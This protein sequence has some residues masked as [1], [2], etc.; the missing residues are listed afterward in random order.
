MMAIKRN[1]SW[2][3]PLLENDIRSHYY[4]LHLLLGQLCLPLVKQR[5]G[6]VSGRFAFVSPS[7]PTATCARPKWKAIQLNRSN[8]ENKGHVLQSRLEQCSCVLRGSVVLIGSLRFDSMAH[9][10]RTHDSRNICLG[11][12]DSCCSL[13]SR[14]FCCQEWNLRFDVSNQREFTTWLTNALAEIS[15]QR[16]CASQ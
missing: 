6:Q 5:C 15:H 4:P 3:P 9:C 10:L 8:L 7:P 2:W 14:R 16:S 12:T 13:S 1:E 11:Y